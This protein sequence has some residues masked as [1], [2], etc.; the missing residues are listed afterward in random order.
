M[1]Y[2]IL[3]AWMS[4]KGLKG[5]RSKAHSGYK[6]TFG[7]CSTDYQEYCREHDIQAHRARMPLGLASFFIK[8]LKE[9]GDLVLDPFAGS[10][11]TGAAA[12]CLG[13]RWLAIEPTV[14]YIEGSRGRFPNLVR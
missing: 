10:N 8:F 6:T 12:E 11:T 2:P 1:R 9:P 13:R 4:T 7:Q 5:T 14:G 3:F